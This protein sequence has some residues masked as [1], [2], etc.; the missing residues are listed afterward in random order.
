MQAVTDIGAGIVGGLGSVLQVPGQLTK[1]V[2]GLYDVGTA[3]EAP[4]EYLSKLGQSFK[5]EGL[6]VREAMRSKAISEA[7][8]DGVLAEFVT[9]IKE[10][11][12]DPAL[13]STFMAEQIPQLIGPLGAAKIAKAGLGAKAAAAT[14]G[15]EGEAAATALKPVVE[16]AQQRATRA[17][18]GTGAVMQ[19]AD[20]SDETYK[21]ALEA[22]KQRNPNISDEEAHAQAINAA[23]L[24]GVGAGG[25]SLLAQKLPGAREVEKRLAGA[26]GGGRLAGFFGEAASE[27]AEEGGGAF[28]KNLAIQQL[29]NPEQSLTAGVG[30]AAGLGAI[31]GGV[32]GGFLSHAKPK[33]E[34]TDRQRAERLLQEIND[35]QSRAAEQQQPLALTYGS[36][37]PY[38]V[39]P[40]GS[41]GRASEVENY[42]KSLPED[43][44][45]GA[46]AKLFGKGDVLFPSMTYGVITD[47]DVKN[48][49]IRNGSA[50][51]S[52]VGLNIFSDQDSVRKTLE[53]AKK[54]APK[55]V[56]ENI[57]NFLLNLGTLQGKALPPVEEAPKLPTADDIIGMASQPNGWVNLELLKQNILTLPQN[58]ETRGAVKTIS[59]IQG[60]ITTES[61]QRQAPSAPTVVDDNVIKKLGFVKSDKPQSL[62]QQL[63]GKDLTKPEDF[64]A[65][66]D[67]LTK[68]KAKTTETVAQRIDTFLQGIQKIP[69]LEVPS[70]GEAVTEPSGASAAVAGEPSAG[71]PAAG[72]RVAEPS[73]V[74][75]TEPLSKPVETRAPEQP[76][77]VAPTLEA[78]RRLR[79][80]PLS[81]TQ[82]K[83]C[84]SWKRRWIK[85]RCLRMFLSLNLRPTNRASLSL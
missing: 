18:I 78:A 49:G 39:F 24:A 55:P 3:I 51:D 44:Q 31:G 54:D 79:V 16:A 85:S 41:A 57:D 80:M 6:K 4:G 30:A 58:K 38:I 9:A 69:T 52:L 43:Q 75:P 46:R 5:S 20:I 2:P 70:V 47:E 63:I 81:S 42:I 1:L 21:A 7:E 45:V 29:V 17:A 83:V 32:M 27:M 67:V 26:P 66:T 65:V 71:A 11:I 8:K 53:S 60:R 72:A 50:K 12:K 74:A 15:L 33:P 23:R 61:I 36:S 22:A 37:D 59:E 35:L 82:S 48:L 28:T 19:G 77:P 64:A 62:Y 68:H 13:F 25:I 14:A 84:P 56:Q 73:G 40:D 10:T 34:E 76:A